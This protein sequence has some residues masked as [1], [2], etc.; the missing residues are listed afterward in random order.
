[1]S[2]IELGDLTPGSPPPRSASP[3]PELTRRTAR[4]VLLAVVTALAVVGLAGGVRPEPGM[5]RPLWS[6]AF[7]LDDRFVVT[8]VRPGDA[9]AV[10]AGGGHRAG[11]RV[12]LRA[13][14]LQVT[15]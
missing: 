6:M 8:G 15:P 4:R 12:R 13:A 5:L 14:G 7:A 3:P 9:A 1:M 11:D 2:V 10:V